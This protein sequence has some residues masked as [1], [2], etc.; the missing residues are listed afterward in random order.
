MKQGYRF[1]D[2][3]ADFRLEIFGLDAGDLF[4][5][6]AGALTDLIV[7]PKPL[8]GRHQRTLTVSG[9]DWADLMVNWLRELLYLWNGEQ[10]LVRDVTAPTSCWYWSWRGWPR[11][12]IIPIHMLS[13]TRSKR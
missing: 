2:H 11:M 4:V 7:D 13:E 1:M 6:A 10:L 8:Q 12:L 5:Q 3:T 9:D